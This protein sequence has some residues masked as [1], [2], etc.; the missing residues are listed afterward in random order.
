MKKSLL[1]V[2]AAAIATCANAEISMDNAPDVRVAN[3]IDVQCPQLFSA[4][5]VNVKDAFQA[6]DVTPEGQ[7]YPYLFSGYCY[8]TDLILVQASTK[9]TFSEDGTKVYFKSIFPNVLEEAWVM[10]HMDDNGDGTQTIT[11][12]CNQIV[13]NMYGIDLVV[14]EF[15]FDSNDNVIGIVDIELTK[16]GDRIYVDDDYE[17]PEHY[18]VL[19][20]E[21]ED[22]VKFVDYGIFF[23]YKRLE[24]GYDA[25]QLPEG[26]VATDYIYSY[27]DGYNRHNIEIGGVYDDGTDVYF[28]FLT[29]DYPAWVVGHHEGDKVIVPAGQYLSMSTYIYYFDPVRATGEKD[30]QG[31][32]LWEYTDAVFSY[33]ADTR[34]YTLDNPNEVYIAVSAN[35][36]AN[37]EY[38]SDFVVSL[39]PGDQPA[40]PSNPYNL[41]IDNW[42]ESFGQV[43]LTYNLDNVGTKGEFINRRSLYYRVYMDDFL[44]EVGPDNYDWVS[45]PMDLIPYDYWDEGNGWDIGPG[46]I[47]FNDDLFNTLGIQAVYDCNGTYFY[48]DIVSVDMDGHTYITEVENED[49]NGI[50]TLVQDTDH[51]IY[52]LQGRQ[53]H[54]LVKGLNI[55]D[56]KKMLVK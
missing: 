10:G 4:K 5:D 34:T 43:A 11:I 3:S 39:Y 13:G 46:F 22:G 12:P 47:Y 18:L 21:T 48:S 27:T 40:I 25:T 45:E 1:I 17:N 56:G 51:A 37:F 38:Y 52:D 53:H 36:V 49:P 9:I 31:K 20:A 26:A 42:M 50:S 2:A 32:D 54:S 41:H 7:E 28:D 44:Y 19:G 35:H 33:D 8:S 16:K 30:D 24:Q 15:L 6:S 55:M 14:G 23:N 29:P